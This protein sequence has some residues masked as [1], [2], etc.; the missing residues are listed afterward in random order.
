MSEAKAGPLTKQ[1]E[2]K[3][4]LLVVSTEKMS[5]HMK[6]NLY[7]NFGFL[8]YTFHFSNVGCSERIPFYHFPACGPYSVE[9]TEIRYMETE[10]S[11]SL[12]TGEA[13]GEGL[14]LD[15]LSSSG[16]SW[17]VHAGLGL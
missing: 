12:I 5:F 3:Y 9:K 15:Q 8:S 2:A 17:L 10:L 7:F 14:S 6:I 11:P 1:Q 4:D 16:S 13:D